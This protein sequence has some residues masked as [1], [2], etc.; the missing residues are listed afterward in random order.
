VEENDAAMSQEG[1]MCLN[2]Y[3]LTLKH[4]QQGDNP[5][6]PLLARLYQHK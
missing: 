4:K 6:S 2:C 3:A 5:S 1:I